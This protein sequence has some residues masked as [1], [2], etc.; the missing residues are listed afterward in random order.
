M[1]YQ[2]YGAPGYGGPGYGRESRPDLDTRGSL[3]D[4]ARLQNHRLLK[5]TDN[6]T[7]R[8][9]ASPHHRTAATLLNTASIRLSISNILL[10][11]AATASH[12]PANTLLLISRAMGSLPLLSTMASRLPARTAATRRQDMVRLL[13]AT[14]ARLPQGLR[15]QPRLATVLRSTSIGMLRATR[16]P[17]AMP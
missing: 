3:A 10:S 1:S 15:P 6:S 8:L 13:Q 12:R 11:T 16:R 4:I 5:A 2:G 7:P 17:S 9:T 14:M